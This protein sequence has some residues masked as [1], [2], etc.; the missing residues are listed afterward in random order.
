MDLSLP[1]HTD[2]TPEGHDLDLLR[3]MLSL[4]P[5]ERILRNVRWVTMIERMRAGLAEGIL[6]LERMKESKKPEPGD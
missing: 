5:A 1:S 3:E 6:A 4:S 2:R